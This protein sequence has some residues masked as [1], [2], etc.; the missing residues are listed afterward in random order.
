MKRI[1]L[2]VILLSGISFAQKYTLYGKVVDELGA[3][4]ENVNVSIVGTSYGAATN[5]SGE[6]RI[7]GLTFDETELEFSRI[8]Y[9]TERLSFTSADSS[10]LIIEL[11]PEAVEADPVLISAGKYEQILSELP[12][13]AEIIGAEEITSRSI[14]NIR[15]VLKYAGS[16]SMVDDQISIRGSSGNSR[17][18]GTR[19]LVALDGMP[20][21]T[22]DTGEIIWEMIPAFE[23]ERIEIIKGAA[24]SLY[25]SSAIGGVVNIITKKIYQQPVTSV[26]TIGG[27]YDEPAFEEWKWSSTKRTFNLQSIAHQNNFGRLGLA[28]SLTRINDAGYRANGYYNRLIGYAKLNYLLTDNS[29]LTF[30]FNSFNQKSG[31]FIYWKDA[32]NALVPPDGDRGRNVESNRYMAGI[33]YSSVL[34]DKNF[35][36]VK[37]SYFNNEWKDQ[38]VSLNESRST[39]FRGEIQLNSQLSEKLLLISGIESGF[40]VVKSNLF[41]DPKAVSGAA[42]AQADY[43]FNFP[44][45]LSAGV[46][47]DIT[48]IDSLTSASAVS[49]KLG[50]NYNLS[51]NLILRSSAGF[52]FRVPSLAEIYTSTIASGIEVRE[53]TLLKPER[54]ISL[55]LGVNYQPFQNLIL[56][57]AIFNNEFYDFI[58]PRLIFENGESFV[59]FENVTRARIQGLELNSNLTSS[60]LNL[61]F[62]ASYTYLN[63]LDIQQSKSL[64]Y[65]PKHQI[66][67]SL[68]Y[69][70]LPIIMGTDFRYWSKVEEMDFELVNLGIIKDGR[71]RVEVFILDLNAGYSFALS[72][73]SFAQII[74]SAK[75]VLNY[76]YVELIA[77]VA[78]IRNYS[79]LLEFAF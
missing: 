31:Y 26:K 10:Y 61:S 71:E 30:Y 12:V 66:K 1:L 19:V 57:A 6:F 29:S 77:N 38:S 27:I 53:N 35:L 78:P 22:G 16:I 76:N 24:S 8:G 21:S 36:T 62:D 4:L 47:F 48:K 50:L 75:N 17:G 55:E 63:S 64:R 43:K 54:N 58:E 28:A 14:T 74:F 60:T 32:L 45:L 33:N 46:R 2:A 20:I 34:S 59:A 15:E 49:P 39:L 11:E 73:T 40:A 23:V 41:S 25:G 5:S 67:L 37:G 69:S 13:S 72:E 3:A 56:D 70:G 68:N 52:G 44:L 7:D 9:K 42:F 18:A 79:L 51:K 65:R